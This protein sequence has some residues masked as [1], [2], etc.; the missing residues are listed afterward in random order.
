MRRRRISARFASAL[1]VLAALAVS[2]MGCT[3]NA[4]LETTF[5]L[6]ARRPGRVPADHDV[7]AFIQFRDAS[8]EFD[9]LWS[10]Q[11]DDHDGVLLGD[12]PQQTG[13]SVVSSTGDAP[14]HVKVRFC[15]GVDGEVSQCEGDPGRNEVG[16]EVPGVWY[17]IERPFFVGHRTRWTATIDRVPDGPAT[18]MT[19]VDKCEIEGCVGTGPSGGGSTFCF[20]DGPREGRH[21]CE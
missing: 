11:P 15:S 12:A 13:F 5:E 19:E 17:R 8:F 14:L 2:S 4:V 18:E 7:Y 20:T 10:A 3:Q 16:S 6:P 1:A 21:F 9:T